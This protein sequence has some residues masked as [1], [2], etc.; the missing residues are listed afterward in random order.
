MTWRS[1]SVGAA[2][3]SARRAASRLSRA[4]SRLAVRR[5]RLARRCEFTSGFGAPFSGT[6]AGAG[7]CQR[8]AVGGCTSGSMRVTSPLKFLGGL[9]LYCTR[10]C[11]STHL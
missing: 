10:P 2:S 4:R 6:A 5:S 11:A 3:S 8:G 7:G 9:S 1:S